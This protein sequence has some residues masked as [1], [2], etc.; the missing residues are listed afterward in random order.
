[1]DPKLT[2]TNNS[3]SPRSVY[4]Y[5][6]VNFVDNIIPP[7]LMDPSLITRRQKV[8]LE[9]EQKRI[10]GEVRFDNMNYTKAQALLEPIKDKK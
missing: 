8:K 1:M 3:V 7:T 10:E 5:L 4:G 6:K 2:D 9:K